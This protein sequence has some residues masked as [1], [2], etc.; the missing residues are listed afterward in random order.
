MDL[1]FKSYNSLKQTNPYYEAKELG[2]DHKIK[3]LLD[4]ITYCPQ[5]SRVS[6]IEVKMSFGGVPVA[7]ISCRL[8]DYEIYLHRIDL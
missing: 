8:C 6:A 1:G 4:Q 3:A 5:C 7:I 2:K